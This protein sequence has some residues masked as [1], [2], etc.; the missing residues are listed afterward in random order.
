M[1][2]KKLAYLTVGLCVSSAIFSLTMISFHADVSLAAF[3]LSLVFT[4]FTAASSIKKLFKEKNL[5]FISVYRELLQ[6]LPYVLLVSFVL[7]RAGA[8]GT[9]YI[10]DVFSVVFWILTS[11]FVLVVLHFLNPKKSEKSTRNGKNILNR[12]NLIRQKSSHFH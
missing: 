7:R 4:F 10:L 8:Y 3:P 12:K 11:V 6:Y 2:T 5:Y 9:P 1:N